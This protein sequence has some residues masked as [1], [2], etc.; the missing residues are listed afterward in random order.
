LSTIENADQIL[1][2]EEGRIIESGNHAALIANGQRYQQLYEKR[3][4]E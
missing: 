3:F 4:E 2:M 1:V